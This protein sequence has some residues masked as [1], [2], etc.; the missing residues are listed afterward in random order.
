MPA[1][2]PRSRKGPILFD[3]ALAPV[4]KVSI[5]RERLNV[6]SSSSSDF[7]SDEESEVMDAQYS[8]GEANESFQEML[9]RNATAAEM[10]TCVPRNDAPYYTYLA[11]SL[12]HNAKK[13]KNP[14]HT[15]VGKGRNPVR[16]TEQHNKRLLDS[17]STRQ[18]S[19]HWELVAFVGPFRT[20]QD[21]VAFRNFWRTRRKLHRRLEFLVNGEFRDKL[22]SE[23]M[24]TVQV[25][26]SP[27]TGYVNS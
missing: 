20:K 24:Q 16:K 1:K 2:K 17:K 8:M 26:L 14:F 4:K 3:F 18:G 22:S 15:H 9:K 25:H 21:G 19:P 7:F 13:D 12:K 5:T 27:A 11:R 6:S 23:Q 10:V